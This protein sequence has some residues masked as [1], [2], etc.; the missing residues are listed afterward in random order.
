MRFAYFD[1]I[2][3]I[4]GLNFDDFDGAELARRRVFRLNKI[5]ECGKERRIKRRKNARISPLR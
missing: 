2:E 4:T 1:Q 3:F 5:S